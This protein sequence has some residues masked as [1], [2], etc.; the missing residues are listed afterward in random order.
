LG[1]Y[2]TD[3]PEAVAIGMTRLTIICLSYFIC[4][5]MD[6]TTG[7]IRGMGVSLQPTIITVLGVCGVRILWVFTVFSI[8]AFHTVASLYTSYPVS[9]IIT[10]IAELITYF[11]VIKKKETQ[12]D[13]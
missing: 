13:I 11:V 8:P 3:S 6:V 7:A 5:A 12:I 2:I 1:I 4:G 9:W 10:F